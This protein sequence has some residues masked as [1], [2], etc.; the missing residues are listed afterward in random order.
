MI[1]SSSKLDIAVVGYAGRFPGAGDVRE[2]WDNICNGVESVS[3]LTDKELLAAGVSSDVLANPRYVKA[4]YQ[5]TGYDLFDAGFFGYSLRDALLIDP[6]QRLFLESC[7]EAL[8]D[9]GYDP[10]R[11]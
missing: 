9:A 3:T 6:Q 10:E 4:A 1:T 7:W 8:E 2:L 11:L 5:L